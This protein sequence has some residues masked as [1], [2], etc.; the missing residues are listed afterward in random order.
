MGSLNN[1]SKDLSSNLSRNG[2]KIGGFFQKALGINQ[3]EEDP[4]PTPDEIA[5]LIR[6]RDRE[7][8]KQ[9]R[10]GESLTQAEKRALDRGSNIELNTTK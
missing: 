9:A 1:S 3:D 5:Q 7:L 8:L 6:E 4:L 10:A 2:S